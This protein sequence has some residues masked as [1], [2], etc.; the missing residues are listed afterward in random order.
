MLKITYKQLD[1]PV[2]I[3]AFAIEKTALQAAALA[4]EEVAKEAK[5]LMSAKEQALA[6]AKVSIADVSAE[7]N[8]L[9]H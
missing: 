5:R 9:H 6:T 8:E 3:A 7:V 1:S 4:A 2:Q